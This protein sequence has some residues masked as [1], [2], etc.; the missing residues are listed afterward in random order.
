MPVP[1]VAHPTHA[2]GRPGNDMRYSGGHLL[3]AAGAPVGLG[4][5]AGDPADEPF[6]V[7]VGLTTLTPT[8]GTVQIQVGGHMTTAMGSGHAPDYRRAW[9]ST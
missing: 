8:E 2:V 5:V 7:T 6:T 1:A 4:R 9:V 3:L